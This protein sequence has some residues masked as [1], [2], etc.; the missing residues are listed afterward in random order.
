[1]DKDWTPEQIGQLLVQDI[2]HEMQ[3]LLGRGETAMYFDFCPEDGELRIPQ[4]D[5]HELGESWI[6]NVMDL[7]SHGEVV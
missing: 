1:M 6:A 5:R 2:M 7:R 4:I 3:R